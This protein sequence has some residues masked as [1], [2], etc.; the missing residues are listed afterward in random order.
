MSQSG[1]ESRLG[2][3]GFRRSTTRGV[4]GVLLYSTALVALTVAGCEPPDHPPTA[5]GGLPSRAIDLLEPQSV[6]TFDLE[7][8]V[9]YRSVR[10]GARPLSVH[11]LEVD[12]GRCELG[13]QVVRADE[14]E[15]R[16]EVSEMA[17]RSEPGVIAAING[18]FFTPED[19]PIG[20]E[21][22]GGE[23][24]GRTSRPVFA[25]R[26]GELPWV[27]PVEW[28]S[29]SLRLGDWAVPENGP[30]EGVQM[31][32]GFPSLLEGGALVGDL[33]MS[34]RPGFSAERHP[35]TAVGF[36]PMRRRL[37]LVVADGRREGVSEGM[38]LL[39]LSSLLRALGAVDAL[40]L[41]GGG[42]SVMVIRGEAVSR[43]SNPAGERPV[44]NGLILRRDEAYCVQDRGGRSRAAPGSP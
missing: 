2:G 39:E 33:E 17:R 29:D 6:S 35:R 3:F 11:L 27:G 9:I 24:R 25:W 43:P 15:G 4:A 14:A 21:V 32:S 37:W 38:T 30:G 18:D 1:E 36:D 23:L 5:F 7:D 22:S 44:V 13:F 12:A 40:N 19:Q 31:V 34:E 16:V 42:S 41:D 8:G 20:V 26:P 10:S 28:E